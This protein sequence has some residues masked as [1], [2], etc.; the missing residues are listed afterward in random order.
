MIKSTIT[1]SGLTKIYARDRKAEG[2]EKRL[3]GFIG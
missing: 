1:I 3:F 2:D